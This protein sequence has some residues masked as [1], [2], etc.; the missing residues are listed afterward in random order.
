M[1]PITQ[2][3]LWVSRQQ[4]DHLSGEGSSGL[5]SNNFALTILK[6]AKRCAISES[7]RHLSGQIQYCPQA[8]CNSQQNRT[9]RS[10]EGYLRIFRPF[11]KYRPGRG[12]CRHSSGRAE[13]PLGQVEGEGGPTTLDQASHVRAPKLLH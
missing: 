11:Q 10:G 1:P 4:T 2:R 9:S 12:H 6:Q 5:S 7:S 8:Y 13:V 3:R